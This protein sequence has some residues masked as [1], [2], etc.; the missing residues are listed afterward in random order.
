M[1][2]LLVREVCPSQVFRT[3][4]AKLRA[5][6]EATW[7]DSEPLEVD[8]DGLRIAS[9]SFFDESFGMLASG[10]PLATVRRRLRPV[11][12]TSSDREL[13]NAIVS[14]RARERLERLLLTGLA[15]L[16][17]QQPGTPASPRDLAAEAGFTED[18]VRP[19]ASSL[20]EKGLL[21]ILSNGKLVISSQGR[22]AV[23]R[24][25]EEEIT[26]NS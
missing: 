15:R 2:R 5:A 22:I 24:I 3:D 14:R 21:R 26:A 12:L 11:G 23:R 18:E 10:H 19:V 17:D 20:A 13:L 6:I 16:W 4:G 9:A 25:G 8:F 7:S 1:G